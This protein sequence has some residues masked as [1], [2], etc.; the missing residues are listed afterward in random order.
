M[1]PESVLDLTREMMR[2][3]LILGGPLLLVALV[4]GL[5]SSVLQAATQV[6]EHT[7]SFVPKLLA[8]AA[9]I[10]VGLPW[11]LARLAEYASRIIVTIPHRL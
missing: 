6:H 8:L 10:L 5:V 9:A 1:T 4:V 2:I 3:C 11:L 7:L